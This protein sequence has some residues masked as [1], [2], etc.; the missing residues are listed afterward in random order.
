MRKKIEIALIS[1]THL[2]KSSTLKIS[3]YEIIRADHP[4]GTAHGGAA[5]I[6]SN[7]IEHSPLPPLRSVNIQSA[8]TTL[9]INSVPISIASCYFSPGISFP[10]PE[11]ITFFQS[12]SHSYIIGADFN[13]KHQTWSHFTN[14]RGRALH[15]LITQKHLKFLS[16]PSPTYWPSHLNRHL[17][18]LD[19][20]ITNL[21]NRFTAVATNLNDPASDHTPVLL[22]IEAQPLMKPN[23]PTI[24]SGFTNWNKFR[25]I[26]SKKNNT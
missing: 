20:F 2:V 24:T 26:L 5:L 13:A 15:N 10:T 6:I 4:D 17:D 14:N 8:C 19:F 11:L 22:Y 16:G 18:S 12:L 21:P 3:G 1:E 25:D 9:K 23:R 7:Q